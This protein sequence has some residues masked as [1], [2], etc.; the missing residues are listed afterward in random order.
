MQQNFY[1]VGRSK[2]RAVWR[3]LKIDR[4]EA[5]ELIIVEDSTL[6]TESECSELLHRIHVGNESTG[7]I[8]F[9]TVCYGIVGML[10]SDV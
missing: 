9:V 3:V 1:L 6:Y 4:S 8:K 10:Y 2:N 5:S 7:G